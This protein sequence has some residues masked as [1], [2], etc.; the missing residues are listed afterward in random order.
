MRDQAALRDVFATRVADEAARVFGVVD[1]GDEGK[2]DQ[3]DEEGD[4]D[5]THRDEGL[6]GVLHVRLA[7]CRYAVGDGL[8]AGE[9]GAS[10]GERA[11]QQQDHAR[12]GQVL[13]LHDVAGALGDGRVASDSSGDADH[14]HESDAADEEIGRYGERFARFANPAQVGGGQQDDESDRDLD[15]EGVQCRDGRDDVVDTGCHRHRDRQHV[16]DQQ[17]RRHDQSGLFAEVLRR[18][19]VVASAARICLDQLAV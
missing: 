4:G 19:L 10:A 8:D 12:L 5:G 14:N 18:D 7:E 9:G 2:R 17:R 15:A 16:V 6:L 3:S 11:Q 13:G 1:T